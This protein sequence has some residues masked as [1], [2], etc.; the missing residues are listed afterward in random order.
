MYV[1][2]LNFLLRNQAW[3]LSGEGTQRFKAENTV[4]GKKDNR[5]REN[6]FNHDHIAVL[7]DIIGEDGISKV[8]SNS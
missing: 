2:S 4:T 8:M 1:T 5:E 6:I 7:L 3:D